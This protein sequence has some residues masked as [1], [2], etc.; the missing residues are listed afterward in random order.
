MQIEI[1]SLQAL[2]E[3]TP[4]FFP[5]RAMRASTGRG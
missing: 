3:G 5:N 2:I 1:L 4:W